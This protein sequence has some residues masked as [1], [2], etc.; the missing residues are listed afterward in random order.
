[1][2]L[3]GHVACMR[4]KRHVYR[5]LME[6]PERKGPLA[7]PRY[8]WEDHIKTYLKRIGCEGVYWIDL[9]QNRVNGAFFMNAM[10]NLR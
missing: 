1:M 4:K 10:V 5:T 8:K 7:R 6:Q 2:R 9:T 3:V